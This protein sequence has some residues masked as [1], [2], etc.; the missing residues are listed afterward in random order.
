MPALGGTRD[1]ASTQTEIGFGAAVPLSSPTRLA[2]SVARFLCAPR[3]CSIRRIR[4][5]GDG[6]WR[7]LS[8]VKLSER[9]SAASPFVGLAKS[10][11]HDLAVRRGLTTARNSD[12][13]WYS[14]AFTLKR[15]H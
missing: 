10:V 1:Y 2:S 7:A 8:P 11:E 5:A 15:G 9:N 14:S 13:P 3:V 12:P 4:R 6:R